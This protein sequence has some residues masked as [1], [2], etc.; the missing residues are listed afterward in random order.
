MGPNLGAGYLQQPGYDPWQV[1]SHTIEGR[2]YQQLS[3]T[4]Q[5]RFTLRIYHQS[6]AAFWCDV[7]P[8]LPGARS[9]RLSP[10][11]S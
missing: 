3:P 5:A 1:Q 4:L 2:I 7:D 11:L 8:G 10:A 9:G 6:Q